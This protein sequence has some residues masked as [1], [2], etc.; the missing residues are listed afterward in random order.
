MN[1]AQ[2]IIYIH[3]SFLFISPVSLHREKPQVSIQFGQA[4]LNIIILARVYPSLPIQDKY[5]HKLSSILPQN[6]TVS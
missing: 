6:Y 5:I 1:Q 3:A 4:L 2:L